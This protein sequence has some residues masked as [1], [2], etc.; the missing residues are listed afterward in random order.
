MSKIRKS[1][2]LAVLVVM[3]LAACN[4]ERASLTGSYGQGVVTGQVTMAAGLGSPAG[5]EVSVRGTG[6]TTTLAE[7]GRFAFAGVP[8]NAALEFRRADGINGSM[9]L[10]TTGGFV[11]IEVNKNGG[12]LKRRGPGG[13]AITELEGTVISAS[14]TQLVLEDRRAGETTVVLNAATV[15]RKGKTPVAPADITA[16]TRVHVRASKTADALTALLVIVQNTSDDEDDDDSNDD[17]G[18]FRRENEG[19]VRAVTATSLTVFT[20]HREEVTFTLNAQTVIRKGK[21]VLTPADIKPDYRVHVRATNSASGPVA[22]LVIVQ[23][24]KSGD[25]DDDSGDDD[26]NDDDQPGVREFEGTVRSATATQLVVFTSHR[27]EVT[28]VLNAQ[29]E[30]R[31]GNERL[32][33]ADLKADM[34]VHVKAKVEGTTNTAVR[35]TVQKSK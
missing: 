14:A 23:S 27:Q 29:T 30:I 8:E 3:S 9:R 24:T 18:G 22:T 31:R 15:I 16:G 33:A 19:I 10:A 7:D 25:D 20:S 5:L 34:R 6:M 1:L 12:S 17:N 21:T 35:V 32:T 4:R 28:F 11:A 26:G 13:E 2:L